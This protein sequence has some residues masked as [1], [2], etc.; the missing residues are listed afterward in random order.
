MASSLKT[1]GVHIDEV[2]AFPN[3]VVVVETAVPAFIGYTARASYQG[4]DLVGQAMEITSL[5]EF[6]IV[7]GV[8]TSP[9]DG[10]APVPADDTRQYYP[11]YHVVPAA[12]PPG[13]IEIGGKPFNLLED[14]GSIYYLYNSLKLFYEN[15][16]SR[17]YVVSAG[18]YGKPMGKA[19]AAGEPLVNPNVQYGA[20]KAAL[21]VLEAENEP[22]MI[23]IPDATLLKFPDYESLMQDV[24]NQCGKLKSRVGI[25][26]VYGGQDPDAVTYPT[27]QV[28]P[29]RTAVGMEH[30]D[31]G[32]VYYPYIKSTVLQDGAID[33]DTLGGVKELQAVLPDAA[34]D[35]VKSILATIQNP[36][37]QNAPARTALENALLRNST[38]YRQLHDLV[39]ERINTLP[40][41]AALA[42]VY[43][44]VDGSEGVWHAP[45]NVSLR[46]VTGTTLN[47]TDDMQQGLNVDAMT[48]KSINAIRVF[49]GLGT[50]VWGARTL[51]GNSDDWRYVNVRRTVIMIEQSV[52]L[53]TR[54]YVFQPNTAST[55]LL[56]ETLIAGFLTRLWQQGALAGDAPAQA[57][58]VAIGLGETMTAQD[59]L[60]G[61]MNITVKVAVSHPAEFIVITVQQQMETS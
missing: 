33:Y 15:G 48:G 32:V 53:A 44:S 8:L 42:G 14:A 37:A 25:L 4:K 40:P 57:F 52:Q 55:W 38:A 2:N 30:L 20:L 6:L 29:F 27:D 7:Y 59:I 23:V 41:S 12:R 17:C 3:S 9:T 19:I 16:G 54:A 60:D 28:L 46:A 10:S 49:P 35:P 21:N 61:L 47:I 1:P 11:I 22:T 36:P 45:A 31:Y 18:L 51:D 34:L 24:L 5:S 26:D 39:R 50:L 58:S 13:D 56:I 43:T